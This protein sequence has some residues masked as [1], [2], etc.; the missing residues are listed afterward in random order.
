MEYVVPLTLR[1]NEEE[2]DIP[3]HADFTTSGIAHKLGKSPF[4]TITKPRI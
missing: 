2:E 1:H 4:T 3:P